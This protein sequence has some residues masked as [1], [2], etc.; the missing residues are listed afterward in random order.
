LTSENLY[1]RIGKHRY[2]DH[3]KNEVLDDLYKYLQAIQYRPEMQD[4]DEIKRIGGY[5]PTKI[6]EIWRS[7]KT[8][9]SLYNAVK[10]YVEQ[11]QK[12]FNTIAIHV[13]EYRA[14]NKLIPIIKRSVRQ[15]KT[16]KELPHLNNTKNVMINRTPGKIGFSSR[17]Y[18]PLRILKGRVD[19]DHLFKPVYNEDKET[20][21]SPYLYGNYRNDIEPVTA[22]GKIVNSVRN[23]FTE[24][25]YNKDEIKLL[26]A[27]LMPSVTNFGERII[28]YLTG[29]IDVSIEV[30]KQHEPYFTECEKT[31]KSLYLV[32][33]LIASELTSYYTSVVS[34]KMLEKENRPTIESPNEIYKD[35]LRIFREYGRD[36]E[37]KP[38]VFIGQTEEGLRDHFLTN[39]TGRYAKTTA[40]GETFNKS[41]K[42]DILLKDHFGNNLFIAECKRWSGASEFQTAINQLF[43]NYISWR[44]T[45]LAL[46]FFVSNKDFSNVLSQVE[47]E[48]RKHPYFIQFTG[49]NNET[50]FSFIFRQKDDVQKQVLLEIML[51]HFSS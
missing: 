19:A 3:V 6:N 31:I 45:N 38:R 50:N 30:R 46:L 39:L 40:T 27:D 36:L 12:D 11:R 26:L 2:P 43:D 9:K 13:A 42:T 28:N 16:I 15:N 49:R 17:F 20:Y 14:M 34:D 33:E 48:A 5:V 44:D 7:D 10:V 22:S 51:F 29:R 8:L 21:S 18:E 4:I 47:D 35:I 24:N 1:E 41:G 37:T 23:Y 32:R 25:L